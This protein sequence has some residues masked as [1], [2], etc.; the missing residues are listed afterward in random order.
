MIMGIV[1]ENV[2]V[3]YVNFLEPKESLNGEL[4]Y[5]CCVLIP[6][7]DKANLARV[8][9]AIEK[10]IVKGKSTKW[11]GKKPKFRYEPLRDGDTELESGDREG[12][13]YEGHYFFNCTM[14]AKA[15]KPGVVDENCKPVMDSNKFYSGCYVHIEVNPYPYSNSGNSGIGWG[16]QNVMFVEDGDRLDGRRSATEAFE[17]LAPQ[18]PGEEDDAF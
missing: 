18:K 16:L 6:K 3:S 13:E 7:D 2:R 4:A 1:L 11:G 5:S 8:E 17:S 14:K 15:G 12:K 9:Q 10:A